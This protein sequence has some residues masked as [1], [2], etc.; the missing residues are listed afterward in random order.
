[1]TRRS[2]RTTSR[3]AQRTILDDGYAIPLFELAQSIGVGA[4]VHGLAFDASS[5]LL[6]HDTWIGADQ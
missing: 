3:T 6:F 1:M 5:R 4:D 2:A